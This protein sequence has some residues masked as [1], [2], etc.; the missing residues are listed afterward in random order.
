MTFPQPV[1]PRSRDEKNFL[2]L[3]EQSLKQ[4]FACNSA[5][6]GRS[7]N[8]PTGFDGG[9]TRR[10]GRESVPEAPQ[11]SGTERAALRSRPP[12][13][14]CIVSAEISED[15]ALAARAYGRLVPEGSA[16][17]PIGIY[18]VISICPHVGD[19]AR[20]RALV[21]YPG[22]GAVHDAK[23]IDLAQFEGGYHVC[24]VHDRGGQ[25]DG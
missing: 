21:L 14:S 11:F 6:R 25:T 13:L 9:V 20:H 22:C 12:V 24:P 19:S 1:P 3:R 5:C 17:G 23:A 7:E 10:H 16:V 18:S 15:Y 8:R 2:T 4:G